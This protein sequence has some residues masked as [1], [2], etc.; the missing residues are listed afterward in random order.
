VHA[1]LRVCGRVIALCKSARSDTKAT[2]I[3]VHTAV[4]CS[5]ISREIF[6]TWTRSN[7]CRIRRTDVTMRPPGALPVQL[8]N[9]VLRAADI[10]E[11]SRN[12]PTQLHPAE[13]RFVYD[14]DV[15]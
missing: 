9:H 7:Q 2:S 4:R 15:I 11:V 3:T 12:A 10:A 13:E 8:T 6:G 5:E 1:C 14:D